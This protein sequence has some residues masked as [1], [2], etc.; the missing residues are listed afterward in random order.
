[1]RTFSRTARRILAVSAM[2][3]VVGGAPVRADGS[4]YQNNS[5]FGMNLPYAALPNGQDEIRTADGT[6]CRSAVGG[7][8]SYL[9][10]GV[11][12]TP[13]G[14]DID[15]S[16]AVYGR[17]VI[18]IGPKAKRL[19][20]TKLYDLEI[21]RLKMELQLARMGLAA[22]AAL[23]DGNQAN[24]SWENEGWSNAAPTPTA[25]IPETQS[26]PADKKTRKAGTPEIVTID[27]L[28]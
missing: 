18:P 24:G 6:S 7:D 17:I 14:G 2:C 27:S 16:A 20:C 28:Y 19:D 23:Q 13:G 10:S 22:G 21:Q 4:N 25:G 15:A 8:G 9:D 5:Q 3:T 26:K 1:M 12:G 11:I